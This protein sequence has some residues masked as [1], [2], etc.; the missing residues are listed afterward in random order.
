M[1][2]SLASKPEAGS[3]AVTVAHEDGIALREIPG[4]DLGLGQLAAR[5]HE[6][7]VDV[8]DRPR[9]VRML[10]DPRQQVMLFRQSAGPQLQRRVKHHAHHFSALPW[11]RVRGPCGDLRRSSG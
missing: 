6:D 5:Q 7:L 1:T 10:D 9:P 4:N 11:H 2:P 3:H 8:T